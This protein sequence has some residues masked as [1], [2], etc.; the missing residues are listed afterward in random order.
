MRRV[1]PPEGEEARPAQQPST[2]ATRPARKPSAPA[3]RRGTSSSPPRGRPSWLVRILVAALAVSASSAVITGLVIAA[4][5]RPEPPPQDTVTDW[6]AGVSYPLPPGWRAGVAAPVA[7]FTSVAG[8]DGS[9]LVMARPA[10]RADPAQ[11]RPALLDL[12]DVY[13][14]LLVLGDDLEVVDDRPVTIGGMPGHTRALRAGGG[15]PAFMRVTLF[16]RPDGRSVVL[17]GVA[18]P[19]DPRSRAEIEAATYG[20]H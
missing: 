4:L 11:L 17:L 16:T 2:V 12:C 6:F 14:R 1:W 10:G 19:D 7:G 8:R 5:G 20:A 9:V 13:A 3:G 15:E 18:Q